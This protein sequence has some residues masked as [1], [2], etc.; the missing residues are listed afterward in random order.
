M[1]RN[2]SIIVCPT[3]VSDRMRLWS[4]VLAFDIKDIF[5]FWH[6]RLCIYRTNRETKYATLEIASSFFTKRVQAG[7][8]SIGKKSYVNRFQGKWGRSKLWKK[9]SGMFTFKNLVFIWHFRPCRSFYCYVFLMCLVWSGTQPKNGSWPWPSWP[10][11]YAVIV[12]YGRSEVVSLTEMINNKRLFVN[13]CILKSQ[14][15]PVWTGTLSSKSEK[16]N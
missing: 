9:L 7:M 8:P 13:R 1:A 5:H 10:L 11:L 15:K 3:L 16:R 2:A 4:S 6:L 12:I 14:V